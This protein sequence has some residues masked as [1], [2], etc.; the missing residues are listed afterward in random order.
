MQARWL[1]CRV[2]SRCGASTAAGL[3]ACRLSHARTLAARTHVPQIL[4]LDKVA[5]MFLTK[6]SIHHERMWRVWME[7]AAGVLPRQ[8]LAAAEEAACNPSKW[9]QL[10][11]ACA[12]RRLSRHQR[13]PGDEG[14]PVQHLFN[15]YVHALPNFTGETPPAVPRLGCCAVRAALWLPLLAPR[16]CP[17]PPA[18]LLNRPSPLLSVPPCAGYEPDTLF[19]GKLLDERVLTEWGTIS[20]VQAERMLLEAALKDPANKQVGCEGVQL[21]CF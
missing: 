1:A 10:Q 2:G 17:P 14:A 21:V 3:P 8:S 12:L 11:K 7:A 5:L 16:S 15:L 4:G 18:G 20:L 19:E 9:E 13:L 6:G